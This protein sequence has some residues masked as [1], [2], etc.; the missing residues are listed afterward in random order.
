MDILPRNPLIFG[1]SPK[2]IMVPLSVA[3]GMDVAPNI[4]LSL[5]QKY[6]NSI[7]DLHF[8]GCAVKV[9]I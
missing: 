8:R 4:F 2:N 3:M 1:G 5:M 7:D 6:I 9:N